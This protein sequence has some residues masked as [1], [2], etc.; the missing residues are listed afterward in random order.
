MRCQRGLHFYEHIEPDETMRVLEMDHHFRAHQLINILSFSPHPQTASSYNH[1]D[2]D[3]DRPPPPPPHHHHHH[4]P[5]KRPWSQQ[6]Q[7]L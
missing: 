5:L 1:S 2:R 3:R 4:H 6:P 7:F